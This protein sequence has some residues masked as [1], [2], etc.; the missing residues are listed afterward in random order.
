MMLEGSPR[1]RFRA[2]SLLLALALPACAGG[3]AEAAV[4]RTALV[5]FGT[6]EDADTIVAEVARTEDEQAT[7]LMHREALAEDGG[8]LFVFQDYEE[9]SF[10]MKDTWIPLDIA[11]MDP[12]FRITGIAALE[13]ESEELVD[14][15]GRAQFALE[16]NRGWFEAHG[17][18]VG[19]TPRIY[20]GM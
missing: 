17:V 20:F 2:L 10:W 7:G 9:R 15:P 19:D 8:M 13:P 6:A 12:T 11:F 16:V 1:G 3:K 14:S 4:P 5:V 18:S